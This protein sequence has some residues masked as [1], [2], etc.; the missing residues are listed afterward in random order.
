LTT[1]ALSSARARRRPDEN[2]GQTL[3]RLGLVDAKTLNDVL[4]SLGGT[5]RIEQVHVDEDL[6]REFSPKFLA[7]H[8]LL[9]LYRDGKMLHFVHAG[10]LKPGIVHLLQQ[11][12]GASLARG[13]EV[14]DDLFRRLLARHFPELKPESAA[15]PPKQA[16]EEELPAPAVRAVVAQRLVRLA[17]AKCR[18]ESVTS[19]EAIARYGLSAAPREYVLAHPV[20]C[21]AC[22]GTGYKGR[23]GMFELMEMSEEIRRLVRSGA[24]VDAIR[25]A[26]VRGGMV[27]LAQAGLARALE[28]VTTVEEV[29]GACL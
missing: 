15:A 8:R 13:V 25:A 28:R 29:V 16:P 19:H 5:R 27:P 20:G 3:L 18:A 6:L 24:G 1:A 9:P 23:L 11:V 7:E 14:G 4:V 22:G 10:A 21:E 26:A 12:T 17:C 2:V